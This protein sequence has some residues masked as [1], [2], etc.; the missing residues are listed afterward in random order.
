MSKIVLL[1][2]KSYLSSK[3]KCSASNLDEIDIEKVLSER[4]AEVFELLIQGITTKEIC[5]KLFIAPS[6][7]ATFKNRILKKFNVDSL[8]GLV[9]FAYK[10]QLIKQEV[11]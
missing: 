9:H 8:V 5:E 1:K 3:N 4:E 11:Y 6:T 2:R 10:H 7:V